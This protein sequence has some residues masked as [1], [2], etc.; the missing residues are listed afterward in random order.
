[1]IHIDGFLEN[2]KKTEPLLWQSIEKTSK[3]GL[4]FIDEQNDSITPTNRL[5]LTYPD[6]HETIS[7]LI[8]SWSERE[9]KNN[10]KYIFNEIIKELKEEQ[11]CN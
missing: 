6:L 4:I 1:M 2:I 7:V 3:E 5:L 9:E 11:K 8:N 10:A